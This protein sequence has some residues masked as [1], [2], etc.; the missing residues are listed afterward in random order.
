MKA[1]AES[2]NQA[3]KT[4]QRSLRMSIQTI[5]AQILSRELHA[6]GIAPPSDRDCEAIVSA[7]FEGAADL[8]QTTT[9]CAQALTQVLL[10]L[11]TTAD[12]S[13]KPK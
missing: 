3:I 5:L 6:R 4:K 8:A 9:D 2:A 7:L 13:E 12:E 10:A 1:I 11:P